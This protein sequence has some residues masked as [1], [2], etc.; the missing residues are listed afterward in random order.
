MYGY[1]TIDVLTPPDE[2]ILKRHRFGQG[3]KLRKN[4]RTYVSAVCVLKD[5][6]QTQ[7]FHLDYYHNSFAANPVPLSGI[8]NEKN[9]SL[10]VALRNKGDTFVAWTGI[11]CANADLLAT[12]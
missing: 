9:I 6:Y 2:V 5:N 12:L 1:E 4:N 10:F 7:T 11:T 8:V 3:S